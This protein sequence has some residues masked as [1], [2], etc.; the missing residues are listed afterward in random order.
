MGRERTTSRGHSGAGEG[1]AQERWMRRGPLP[2]C[3]AL[4]TAADAPQ[5]L[6]PGQGSL[7]CLARRGDWRLRRGAGERPQRPLLSRL[8][9]S[10]QRDDAEN[11]PTS[12]TP[13]DPSCA[14]PSLS[15]AAA[16][17][18]SLLHHFHVSSTSLP[19]SLPIPPARSPSSHSPSPP[20]HPSPFPCFSSCQFVLARCAPSS[21]RQC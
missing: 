6:T 3:A 19:F 14:A 15:P 17:H 8:T 7:G 20:F 13:C 1:G 9:A 5:R 16:H 2:H 4:T 12:R 18:S 11:R 21:A 10:P